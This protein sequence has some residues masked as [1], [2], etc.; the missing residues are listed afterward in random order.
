[1]RSHRLMKA[2]VPRGDGQVLAR[3]QQC[4]ARWRASRL[5]RIASR[6]CRRPQAPPRGPSRRTRQMNQPPASLRRRADEVAARLRDIALHQRACVEVEVQRSASTSA[7]ADPL[8]R[9][10]R[11]GRSGCGRA[12]G[13]TRP[14][15]MSA[16]SASSRSDARRNDVGHRTATHRDPD[17]GR[18]DFTRRNTALRLAFS[19]RRSP[20][21]TTGTQIDGRRTGRRILRLSADRVDPAADGQDGTGTADAIGAFS[22]AVRGTSSRTV[23]TRKPMP[24]SS[25][26][27]PMTIAKVATLSAK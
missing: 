16:R 3:Q 17:L 25:R 4:G 13:T 7:D 8:P 12:G 11:G 9:A 14:S 26:A 10:I 24:V 6:N 27:K 1:M 19:S 5:P 15:A 23:S 2:A 21:G 22:L 20:A 18:P